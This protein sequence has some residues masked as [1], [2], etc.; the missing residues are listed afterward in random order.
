VSTPLNNEHRIANA[1]VAARRNATALAQYPGVAPVDLDGAYAIQAL[2][3]AQ[4]PDTVVGWKVGRIPVDQVPVLGA[5]R[6]AGPIFARQ[7]VVAPD[8]DVADMPIFTNGFAAVEAEYVAVLGA[9]PTA[10]KMHFTHDEAA[11]LIAKVHYGIEIASS[12]LAS[13]NADGSAVTVSDF[14]NNAGLLLGPEIEAWQTSGY[15]S[16]PVAVTLDG[17]LV[18]EGAA[19]AMLD[20]PVGAVRYLLETAAERG[21]PLTAGMYISSGAVTGVHSA[22]VAA[23]A[24][25]TFGGVVDLSCRLVAFTPTEHDRSG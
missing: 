18:G 10:G 25:A 5:V 7:V 21:F 16:W 17:V 22:A 11:A 2:A 24:T 13:I 12:P 6:L 14:G 3:I 8:D 4:W 19:D 20:G 1:F 23:H 9:T 15:E